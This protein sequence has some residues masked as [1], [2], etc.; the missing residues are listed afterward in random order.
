MNYL[1]RRNEADD[2][3]DSLIETSLQVGYK[4][5]SDITKG[6]CN[7]Y[8]P[9][10]MPKGQVPNWVLPS[11]EIIIPGIDREHFRFYSKVK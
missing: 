4:I 10:S 1:N 3:Y 8:S 7:F 6:C 5:V 11:A 2:K 9:I